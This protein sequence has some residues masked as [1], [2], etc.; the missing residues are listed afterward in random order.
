MVMHENFVAHAP[1]CSGILEMLLKERVPSIAVFEFNA[2]RIVRLAVR[3]TE[4]V[5]NVFLNFLM[6]C[7]KL[8]G[9]SS[10]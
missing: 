10:P 8:R 1:H 7:S 9:A 5:V 2:T 6:Y 3:N 4:V